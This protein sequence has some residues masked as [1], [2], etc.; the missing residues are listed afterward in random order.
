[1]RCLFSIALLCGFVGAGLAGCTTYSNIPAQ[2]GDVA[3]NDPNDEAVRE[4]MV[5][6]LT[7]VAAD[8]SLTQAFEVL[9]PD[10]ATVGT[11]QF[12]VPKVSPNATSIGT[13]AEGAASQPAGTLPQLEVRRLRIRGWIAQ[14][15]IVRPF[16]ASQPDG[17]KQ[18]ATVDLKWSPI[19]HWHVE[20]VRVW[21][22][23]VDQALREAPFGPTNEFGR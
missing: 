6:S 14:V 9:L 19:D 21:R 18:L 4:V 22:T 13:K 12:V 16:S 10:G 20:G 3:R 23:S 2:A 7:A 1:M 5:A 11:Y 15:D 8:A 17:L